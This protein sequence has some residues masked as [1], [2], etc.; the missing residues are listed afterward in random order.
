MKYDWH[1]NEKRDGRSQMVK[2][3]GIMTDPVECKR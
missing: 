1:D 2:G 3:N